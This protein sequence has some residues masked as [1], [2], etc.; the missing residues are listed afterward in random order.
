MKADAAVFCTFL[1]CLLLFWLIP[2]IKKVNNFQMAKVQPQHV[3]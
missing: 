3:A 1:E 2:W